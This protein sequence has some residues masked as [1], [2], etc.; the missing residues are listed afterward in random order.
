[1]KKN[2]LIQNFFPESELLSREE[3]KKV[4]GGGDVTI[5]RIVCTVIGVTGDGTPYTTQGGCAGETLEECWDAAMN[6]CHSISS[7]VGGTCS[8]QCLQNP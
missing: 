3:M 4:V 2:D 8:W 7:S 5:Q 1:M 6:Q